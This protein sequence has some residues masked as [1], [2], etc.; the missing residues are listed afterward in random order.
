MNSRQRILAAIDHKQPDGIPVDFGSTTVTGIS[1]TAYSGLTR[2]LGMHGAKTR[3]YDVITQLAQP[4]EQ[5][6][7][8]FRIDTADIGRLFNEEDEFWYDITLPNAVPVQYPKW[9]QPVPQADGSWDV[10]DTRG[11]RIATMPD[12]ATFF[13]QT[14]YPYAEGY[15][16]DYRDL[17]KAMA[18][19]HWGG[20]TRSPW[21]HA[22]ESDFWEQLR[23]RSIEF[24][25]RSD[26][27]LIV[28]AGCSVFEWGSFLR[29]MD[30]FLMDVAAS[31]KE[32]ERFLD[33]LMEVHMASLEKICAAVGDVADIVRFGDDLGSNLGP[34]ISPKAYRSLF[35]P[36]HK[37]LCEYVRR[38]SR[39][40]TFLHSC[41]SVYRFIPDF[42]EVGYDILNPVQITARDMQ[43]QDLK[44]EYGRDITFWGGGCDTRFILTQAEPAEVMDHVRRNVEA[45]LP[46]GGYVFATVHNVLSD[47][48]PENL[49]A[50][51]K[52]LDEFR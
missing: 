37:I 22:G 18:R 30:N 52:A 39:M 49:L 21:D 27:A 29:R 26:R 14:C 43:P 8:H 1:A 13:D 16:A 15:P 33:A 5:M 45:F 3:V 17:K 46:G 40:R 51:F 11:E 9:F 47:A 38:H 24:R 23:K 34:L 10:F 19:V 48:R 35:K 4:D 6:L 7:D 2:A 36:R 32:I 44:R 25:Q 12:G 41:G 31:P 28:T 42:I 50:M 20:L